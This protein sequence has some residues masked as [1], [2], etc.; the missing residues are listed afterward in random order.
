MKTHTLQIGLLGIIAIV[1]TLGLFQTQKVSIDLDM[2][3]H[4]NNT[5]TVT[6]KADR[7]VAPDTASISFFVTK[8][9]QDQKQIADFINKKTKNI[10][11]TV[12]EEGI[13]Q[14]DI[15]TTNYSL[16][17]EYN[18]SDGERKFTGY[19]A[20]QNI[21]ITVRDLLKA[22]KVL[23]R[24]AE[25]RVDNISGPNMYVDKL[26]DIK[27]DL[28]S[29]AIADAKSKA[30]ELA[31]ELGVKVSKIVSFSEEG[32]NNYQ[33]R[34]MAKMAFAEDA[35]FGAPIEAPEINPGEEKITKTVSITFKI[36][37]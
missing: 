25:Q 19:R 29:E 21:T 30:N 33:P 22:P 26:D 27:D 9:G 36:E 10:T 4:K 34:M 18:W 16:N 17:P 1:L 14:K 20:Q 2:S 13:A 32:N 12:R 7:Q 35:S 24:V 8:R 23:A 3:E 5:I 37:N 11:A 6:G 31:R 28:R 15:K